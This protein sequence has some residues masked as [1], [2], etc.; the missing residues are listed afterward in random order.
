MG[1]APVPDPLRATLT[2]GLDALGLAEVSETQ[3]SALAEL[4]RILDRWA[5]RINLTAHRSP[6]AIARNL[7]LDAAA[8]IPLLPPEISTLADLGSGA[9]FPGLPLSI[10]MPATRVCLV[11]S[12]ERRHHFQREVVRALGLGNARPIRGRGEDP[13]V[14]VTPSD[15]VVA[16]AMA[17]PAAAVPTMLRWARPGGLLVLPGG[18]DPPDPGRVAA[19]SESRVVHYRLPLSGR[20]RTAWLG[21]V[22]EHL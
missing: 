6:D 11:E 20:P 5:A 15:V 18:E 2:E 8:L 4:A 12:R 21:T 16:Q 22:E 14:E 19:I 9:G 13:A 10:L 1:E 7:I 3:A 17:R